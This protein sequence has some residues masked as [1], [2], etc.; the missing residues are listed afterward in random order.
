MSVSKTGIKAWQYVL[1]AFA[2]F[3]FFLPGIATLPPIDRDESRFVQASKQMLETNDFIDIKFQNI[4]R[5]KKPIGIYW[6]QTAAVKLTGGDAESTIWR[7]RLV[8]VLS[9]VA[10]VLLITLL[11]ARMFGT[12][13][14]LAAGIMLAGLLGLAFEGRIAKTDGTLLAVTLL[15]Q[16]ALA[17]IYLSAKDGLSLSKRWPVLLWLA[18]G[19]VILI[20]GP[21]TLLIVALTIIGLVGF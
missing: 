5:Y 10:S 14:G 16:T 19:I 12:Q 4:D 21:I 17:F 13:T 1:L 3:A 7:Y 15:A 8:S 9:G 2:A 6:L 20:K 18:V 11:G